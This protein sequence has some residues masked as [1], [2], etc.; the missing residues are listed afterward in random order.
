MN[1]LDSSAWIEYLN[2][3]SAAD[4]FEAVIQ[5]PWTLLVPSVCI[6]E[7]RRQALRFLDRSRA[8]RSVGA[9]VRGIV[10][11]LDAQLAALAADLGL[12]HRLALAGSIIYATA[13][14]R[15]ATLWTMDAD[16]KGLPGVEYVKRA[17]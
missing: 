17:E 14:S 2:D 5:D 4:A 1:V 10:V 13:Q 3:G 12:E 9:M 15:E 16:F 11:D 6:T 8:D 7:V